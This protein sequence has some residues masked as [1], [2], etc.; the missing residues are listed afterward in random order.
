MALMWL[1]REDEAAS[2]VVGWRGVQMGR[3]EGVEAVALGVAV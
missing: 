3:T 2:L 1:A